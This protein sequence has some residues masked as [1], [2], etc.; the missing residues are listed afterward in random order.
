MITT[1]CW[2][3]Q[4][5]YRRGDQKGLPQAGHEVPPDYNPGDKEAEEKF[6]EINEANE[7]LSDPKKRQLY[8]QYGFAGGDPNYAAQ[9]GGGPAALAVSAVLAATVLTLAIF[10]ATSLRRLRRFWRLEPF[11]ESQRPPQGS[12]HPGAHHPDV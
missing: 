3:I 9:N 4:D 10:S 5:G 2:C 12:G 6:K 8:D 11:G 7:V 1:K